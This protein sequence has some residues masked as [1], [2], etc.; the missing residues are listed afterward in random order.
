MSMWPWPTHPKT[1]M[2]HLLT[3]DQYFYKVWGMQAQ[4]W[5]IHWSETVTYNVFATLTPKINTG[6]DQCTHK[7]EVAFEIEVCDF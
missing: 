7:M 4:Q 1:N 3:Y 5:T 2:D 6:H